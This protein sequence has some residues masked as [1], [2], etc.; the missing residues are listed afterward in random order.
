MKPHTNI[1]EP[2]IVISRRDVVQ[3]LAGLGFAAGAATLALSPQKA[4]AVADFSTN[5]V[6]GLR[7]G[8]TNLS[9]GALAVVLGYTVADDGGGGV[10][11]WDGGSTE[12]DNGGTIIQVAGLTTGRWKRV[13]TEPFN[14][15]WFGA[16]GDGTADDRAAIQSAINAALFQ[17]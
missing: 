17:G 6:G 2:K 13:L 16:K 5:S 8:P 12:G 3:K 9:T 10:F 14:V 11:Y 7:G 15:K 4:E 1:A